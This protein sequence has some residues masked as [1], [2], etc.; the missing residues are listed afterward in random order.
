MLE[1]KKTTKK[2]LAKQERN[3]LLRTHAQELKIDEE[4]LIQSMDFYEKHI[5]I[6]GRSAKKLSNYQGSNYAPVLLG[7]LF[8]FLLE[9]SVYDDPEY[10]HSALN[11]LYEIYLQAKRDNADPSELFEIMAATSLIENRNEQN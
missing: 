3:R 6:I 11:A 9:L 1:E 10:L 2:Q 4:E 5:A 7:N 8:L